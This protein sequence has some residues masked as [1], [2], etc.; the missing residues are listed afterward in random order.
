IVPILQS[1]PT[2]ARVAAGDAV[3]SVGGKV[4][5]TTSMQPAIVLIQGV[6]SLVAKAV[7]P[8]GGGSVTFDPTPGA[9]HAG[10]ELFV[11]VFSN[12]A[13]SG[14]TSTVKAD[15]ASLPVNV[16]KRNPAPDALD[17]EGLPLDPMSGGFHLWAT[18]F[19]NGELA[20]AESQI[21]YPFD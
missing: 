14:V 18:G 16:W 12:D 15:G 5:V 6:H 19:Y 21:V 4:T 2:H 20:F 7:I 11:T 13:V 17:A 9:V 10:D 3:W 1:A 8:A